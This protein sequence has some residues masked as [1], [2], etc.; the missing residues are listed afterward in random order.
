MI[1]QF[2]LWRYASFSETLG[3]SWRNKMSSTKIFSADGTASSILFSSITPLIIVIYNFNLG[4]YASCLDTLGMKWRNKN[5]T[6]KSWCC[7]S[8]NFIVSFFHNPVNSCDRT[9]RFVALC[10]VFRYAWYEMR[11]KTWS[12]K[13]YQCCWCS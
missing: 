10:I 3:M 8:N 6:T 12:T 13:S 4:R 1:E 2:N 5:S 7:Y 11:N 9:V